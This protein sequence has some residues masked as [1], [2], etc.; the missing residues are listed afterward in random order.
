M[1]RFHEIT[2]VYGTTLKAII[3]E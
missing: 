2:Q 1:Y 3:H